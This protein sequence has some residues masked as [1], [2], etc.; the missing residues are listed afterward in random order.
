[1]LRN[2]SGNK[3]ESVGEIACIPE[4]DTEIWGNLFKLTLN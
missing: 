3:V 2:F 4:K 1:M